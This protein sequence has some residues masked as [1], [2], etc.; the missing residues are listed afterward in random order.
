MYNTCGNYY[1]TLIRGINPCIDTININTHIPTENDIIGSL[2]KGAYIHKEVRK[3]LYTFLKP[4]MK[5]LDIAKI[6]ESKT[7]EL[8]INDNTIN[9]GIGFP[10]SLSLNNCA[11][12]FHPLSTD[13]IVV[14]KN[15][16]LKIDFGVEINGWIIDSAFTISFDHKYDNLLKA[17]KESTEVGIK[18]AGIDVNINDWAGLIQE[19]MES[20]EIELN[21]NNYNIKPIYNLGGH[22]ILKE[23]IHGGVF[24]PSVKN[25]ISNNHRFEEGVYAIETFGSTGNN[26]A[27]SF[28]QPLSQH[29]PTGHNN[30]EE[31]IK[32]ACSRINTLYMLNNTYID[33]YNNLIDN[34]KLLCDKI[35]SNYK[36][37]PFTDRYIE[38]YNINNYKNNIKYLCDNNI[39]KSYPPL[40]V[41]NNSY[42]AQYEH[43]VYINE[44]K[45]IIFSQNIDY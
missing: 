35:I 29:D 14:K 19:T 23:N 12:H 17:V 40:F 13:E 9:N 31:E 28:N 38:T 7:K 26:Y 11:A 8:S 33:Y 6:I 45:K 42:T 16:V 5:L 32:D 21:N 15:D 4:N 34:N 10:S 43:T 20:Y 22:N 24:L 44:N 25:I 37:I 1:N 27:Q 30:I 2:E 3:H 39:I 36:T 41:D 18:N